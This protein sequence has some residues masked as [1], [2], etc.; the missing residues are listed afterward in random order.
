MK[1]KHEEDESDDEPPDEVRLYEDGSKSRYYES[2]FEVDKENV[3]FRRL[4]ANEYA[5]GL[6]WVLR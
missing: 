6:C 3:A 1:R 4:V 2:K 5:V